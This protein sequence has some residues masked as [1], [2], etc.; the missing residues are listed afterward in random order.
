MS[1]KKLV[2]LFTALLILR[3]MSFSQNIDSLKHIFLTTKYDTARAKALLDMT[4]ILYYSK[5]DTIIPLCELSIKIIEG[6]FSGASEK[7][8]KSFLNTKAGALNN[9]GYIYKNNGN[10]AKALDYYSQSLKMYELLDDKIGLSAVSN[11]IGLIYAN[12]G[13]GKKGMPYL[14]RALKLREEVNDKHG[15]ANSLN[16]IASEYKDEGDT[17]KAL[18]YFDKSLKIEEELNDKNGLS[19]TLDNIGLTYVARRNYDKAIEYYKKSLL[20]SEEIKNKREMAYSLN[21]IA[22]AL[23]RQGKVNEAL[24]FSLRCFKISQELGYPEIIKNASSTLSKIYA[25]TGNWK[26]AYEMHVILKKMD[27]SLYNENTHKTALQKEFQYEFEKK[28]AADSVKVME[29]NKVFDA[30]MGQERTQR[31]GLYIGIVLISVFSLFMYNRF[32]ITSKQKG[33]IVLQKTEVDRQRELAD[34]RRIIA[35]EQRYIIETK[36]KEILDSIHYASRIQQAMLTSKEYISKH[37]KAEYFI[38]YQPKD[39]VSGD[40]YWAVNHHNKFYIAAA[41]CTGHGVPGAFMSLLNISFLTENVIERGIKEP[42][43]VLNEQRKEIIKALN[44]IGNENSKD[45]MDCVLCAFDLVNNKLEFA[46]AN[47]PLWLIRDNELIQYKADKMPV[48]KG[49]EQAKDFTQQ[50]IDI[51]K[52]DMVYIFTDGYADQFGG[53]K[54]KKFMYKQLSQLLISS[55]HLPLSEQ[56]DILKKALNDWKGRSEQIDDILIIG[57]KIS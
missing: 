46:A 13:D 39:I 24:A 52:G 53:P 4:D 16:N 40:F 41:D 37:L 2:I 26:G 25:Q 20:F 50:T 7:E 36:Q 30:R 48:G 56:H 35:E 17:V 14:L 5:P 6:K 29:E 57:L 19:L 28:A 31:N 8:K 54:G 49:E 51:R 42:A 3:S 11:N 32:R 44:P 43:K 1:L 21:Y 10:I 47:N 38:F 23:L 18:E 45:G 34:S 22:L 55:H 27:D 15:I 9:I 12:Q 33:I